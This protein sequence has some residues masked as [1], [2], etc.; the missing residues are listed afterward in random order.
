MPSSVVRCDTPGGHPWPA[1]VPEKVVRL[2]AAAE[3]LRVVK[4]Q[5]LEARLRTER[6][7]APDA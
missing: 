2:M 7:G 1:S 4:R 5:L 3:R 6:R